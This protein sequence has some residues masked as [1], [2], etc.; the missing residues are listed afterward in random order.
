MSDDIYM[1]TY[2]TH[3]PTCALIV[4][5]NTFPPGFIQRLLIGRDITRHTYGR[6]QQQSC[7]PAGLWLLRQHVKLTTKRVAISSGQDYT[8]A[9]N[10]ELSQWASSMSVFSHFGNYITAFNP[11]L[12]TR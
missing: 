2:G 7:A 9:F 12:W 6:F 4:C 1:Q 8:Q 10:D 5:L 11:L 3:K